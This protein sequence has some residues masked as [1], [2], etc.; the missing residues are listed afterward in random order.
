VTAVGAG[1][2]TKAAEDRHI[3][4]RWLAR[5]ARLGSEADAEAVFRAVAHELSRR[6]GEDESRHVAAHL[7][8]GLRELWVEESA[9]AARP[10]RVGRAELAEAVRARLDLEAAAEAEELLLVVLGW[11]RHLA[12]EEIEDVTA[13][14]PQDLRRLWEHAR[15]VQVPPWQRL[16]LGRRRPGEQEE[17]QE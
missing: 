13:I 14:L 9:G 12:P 4:F 15:L 5:T 11:L 7:P 3:G 17:E 2:G 1:A 6:L 16:V 8:L 10:A